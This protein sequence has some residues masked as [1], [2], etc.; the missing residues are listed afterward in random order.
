MKTKIKNRFTV[1]EQIL[2][3]VIIAFLSTLGYLLMM[4]G[5]VQP[6]GALGFLEVEVSDAVVL[7]AYSLYGFFAS[8]F[9]AILKT[10]LTMLTFGP[11]G[12]PIPIGQIT[13]LITSLAYCFALFIMDKVFGAF[14]KGFKYRIFSYAFVIVF[15]DSLMT[16]LN[17]LFITPTFLTY[18]AQF[19]TCYDIFNNAELN[20]SF[21]EF[22]KMFKGTYAGIIFA[23]YFPFNLVKG[24]L[25]CFVYELIFNRVIYQVLKSGM[26]GNNVFMKADDFMRVSPFTS[27]LVLANREA[28]LKEKK[29]RLLQRRDSKS[30]SKPSTETKP[31]FLTET[32]SFTYQYEFLIA[33]D[34][35]KTEKE[36]SSKMEPSL[37]IDAYLE[38]QYPNSHYRVIS[39]KEIKES[40]TKADDLHLSKD[41]FFDRYLCDD[42]VKK[43]IKVEVI[44]SK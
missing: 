16:Y 21:F 41:D 9:V 19:L 13:A 22:F 6:Y 14:S 12:S 7:V 33:L 40:H 26:L 39:Q 35:K 27:L 10:I 17:Y 37:F 2:R 44:V 43:T 8:A 20:S 25:V 15:V 23:V 29:E 36:S 34:G 1:H 31:S 32:K 11:V 38:R 4:L 24:L 18:G 3:L 42:L 30:K 5:K 28:K